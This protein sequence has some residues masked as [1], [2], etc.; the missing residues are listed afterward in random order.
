MFLDI[1]LIC[2]EHI[3]SINFDSGLTQS[4]FLLQS[5]KIKI[6]AKHRDEGEPVPLTV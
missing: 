2:C 5:L 3:V 1:Q 4:S 6:T